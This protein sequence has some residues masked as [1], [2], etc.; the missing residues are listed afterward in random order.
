MSPMR[1]ELLLSSKSDWDDQRVAELVQPVS[2]RLPKLT[3]QAVNLAEYDQL[4]SQ[5]AGSHVPA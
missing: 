1:L 5:G 2:A 3:P 4:L